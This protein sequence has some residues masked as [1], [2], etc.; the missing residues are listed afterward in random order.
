MEVRLLGRLIGHGRHHADLLAHGHHISG[1]HLEVLSQAAVVE[2]IVPVLNQ[3]HVAQHAVGVDLL[4]LAV[5]AGHHRGLGLG[6][7]IQPC[8]DAPILHG[9]GIHR[10]PGAVGMQ[11]LASLNGPYHLRADLIQGSVGRHLGGLAAL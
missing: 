8:V 7:D 6:A 1:L 3:G 2:Q 10:R 4:H 11:H 9:L 5:G